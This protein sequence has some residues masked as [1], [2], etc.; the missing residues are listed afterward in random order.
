MEKYISSLDYRLPEI[1]YLSRYMTNIR[2]FNPWSMLPSMWEDSNDLMNNSFGAVPRAN[3]YE[4]EDTV[5]VEIE[6]PGY[7]SADLDISITGDVLK[8]TGKT[9][10]KTEENK[11]KRYYMSE[12]SEKSFTRTFTLPYEV[13]TDKSVADFKDGVLKLTLPK[14]EKALPKTIRIEAK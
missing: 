7:T 2:V 3:M 9:Q 6:L 12:I 8:V 10:E 4:K 1:I 11:G 5:F 13:V 14:S